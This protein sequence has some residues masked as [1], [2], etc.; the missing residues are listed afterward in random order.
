[1]MQILTGLTMKAVLLI[2]AQLIAVFFQELDLVYFILGVVLTST[3]IL[4]QA[5]AF[6]IWMVS[7]KS[8]KNCL[9][10]RI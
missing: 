6:Q 2:S 4:S 7:I 1:M 9:L 8:D 10:P 3:L 5:R